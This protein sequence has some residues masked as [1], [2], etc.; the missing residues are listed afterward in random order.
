MD[1]LSSIDWNAKGSASQPPKPAS[2]NPFSTNTPTLK[3]NSVQSVFSPQSQSRPSS[4]LSR[5]GS[6]A[7]PLKSSTPANDLFSNLLPTNAS[8]AKTNLTLQDRQRQLQEERQRQIQEQQ[9]RQAQEAQLWD[10]LGTGSRAAQAQSSGT[11]LQRAGAGEDVDDILAAFNSKAKVDKSSHFPPPGSNID[12]GRST[13]GMMQAPG[14]DIGTAGN[15]LTSNGFD[16]DDDPF[17]L[18]AMPTSKSHTPAPAPAALQ[19]DDILGDLGKPV[20][21][22]APKPASPPPVREPTPEEPVRRQAHGTPFDRQIAE[23]VDMGFPDDK[24]QMALQETNGNLQTAV[25][26]LLNQAHSE[27]QQKAKGRSTERMQSPMKQPEPQSQGNTPA[28]MRSDSRSNSQP[29]RPESAASGD[30]DVSQYATEVGSAF[31]KSANSLW[32]A[33][34]KQVQKAVADFQQDGD[35]SQPKWMRDGS[36]DSRQ[37]EHAPQQHKPQP[38]GSNQAP[39]ANVTDEALL[40]EGGAGRPQRSAKASPRIPQEPQMASPL[41]GRSPAQVLPE[42][43]GPP[44]QRFPTQPSSAPRQPTKLS[45]E[46]VEEQASQAYVSSARRRKPATPAAAAKSPEPEVDLF[47][48]APARQPP[49]PSARPQPSPARPV[50]SPAPPKPKAPPRSVPSVSPSVLAS[51]ASHRAKGTEAFKCG[52]YDSAHQAYTSALSGIPPTHPIRI[53]ILSNRSLTALKTGDPKL[54]ISD[55]DAV[56]SLIGPSKGENESIDVGTEGQKPMRDFFGKA[57]TRKAEALESLE[58][59]ADAASVWREAV[60]AGV[61]GLVA[62]RGRDRCARAADPAAAKPTPKATPRPAS[63][64]VRPAPRAAAAGTGASQDA[65]NKLRAQNAAAEKLDDER[66]ALSDAVAARI[67]A[68][69]GGKSDNLRALLGSLE[70]VLWEGAGWKKVG[71]AELIQVNR[72]KIVYMKAIARVH[73]DKIPQDAT[74]EQKMISG[75]VFSTLNEAWD[76]FKSENGL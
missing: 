15:G 8:K 11:P 26:W 2:N 64:P 3:P 4:G 10:K 14:Q 65:V 70:N 60:E 48:P 54:A 62:V 33:G 21:A 73:P 44:Q 49:A 32:K 51:S 74:T 40:L 12:S 56:L 38:N 58:K 66:F 35:S 34:R 39:A 16:D 27:A 28:W 6:A 5:G 76:K 41:R 31:F 1:D 63:K 55:A 53:I 36:A 75:S 69:R 13:P 9:Q 37:S 17:G 50:A 67:E 61:G 45:R 59:W 29:R 25:S 72:V 71:M 68:W 7:S 30:K 43:S 24:A 22:R 19:D 20:Q 46:Q 18:G 57:L 47:S 42:R 52:D 23:L